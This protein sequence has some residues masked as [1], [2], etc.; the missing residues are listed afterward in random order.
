MDFQESEKRAFNFLVTLK[1]PGDEPEFTVVEEY[2]LGNRR[3][4]EIK[5]APQ[6]GVLSGDDDMHATNE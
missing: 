3:R 4:D 6:F 5:Y 1:T 2:C